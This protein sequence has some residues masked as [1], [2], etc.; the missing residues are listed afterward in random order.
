MYSFF[1]KV[2]VDLDGKKIY[3]FLSVGWGLLADIDVESEVLRALGESRFTIWSFYRLAKLRSYPAKLTYTPYVNSLEVGDNISTGNSADPVV[4]EGDFVCIYSAYQSYI[5][6][7][8]VF[9]PSA[10]P[11]DGLIHLVYMLGDIGRAR[12]TQFLISIDKGTNT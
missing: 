3:S 7:D 4:V 10:K 8:L 12:A 6:S 5:G 9:A 2:E 1:E 11:N